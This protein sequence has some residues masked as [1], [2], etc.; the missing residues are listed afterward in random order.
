M[1][2]S[3]PTAPKGL[4]VA[5]AGNLLYFITSLVLLSATAVNPLPARLAVLRWTLA[6]HAGVSCARHLQRRALLAAAGTESI[7][8]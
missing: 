8:C 3:T 4:R 2:L 6:H 1:T 5:A 7:T